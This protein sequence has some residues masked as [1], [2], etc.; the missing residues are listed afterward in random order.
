M[1]EQQANCREQNKSRK[2][3]QL[4]PTLE[5]SL[6]AYVCTAAAAG[7]SLLA[8][9]KPAGAE[10]VYTPANTDIPV[11]GGLVSLDLN[12]D[13]NPDFAFWNFKTVS[14]IFNETTFLN[15]YAG[16]FPK[17]SR[18]Q[19]PVNRIWGEGGAYGKFA[20]ALN[21]GLLIGPSK[22]HFQQ[23]EK[24][25]YLLP[26]PVAVQAHL[27]KAETYRG[28][29]EASSTSGQWMYTRE[30]DLGLQFAINGE[31]HYGWA[32]VAVTLNKNTEIAATITGYAYETIANKPI[33]AGDEGMNLT[34]VEPATLGRLAQGARGV[35]TG[36]RKN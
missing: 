20:S 19:M 31:I 8:I 13:G 15:L 32:R 4:R 18:C 1:A 16:C 36:R 12:N 28:Y 23:P 17:D 2:T 27:R 26:N 21:P 5:K 29:V 6:L 34:T 25:R 30:R 33:V 35:Q 24:R 22:A 10:V 14:L 11:N 3:T 7:A 9:S